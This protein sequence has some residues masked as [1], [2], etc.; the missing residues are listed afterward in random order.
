MAKSKHLINKL[1]T[2]AAQLNLDSSR[3][4]NVVQEVGSDDNGNTEL[5]N[6]LTHPVD[7]VEIRQVTKEVLAKT[8]ELRKAV[9]KC[10]GEEY[11]V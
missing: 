10:Q 7:C 1:K 2:V 8:P 5:I 4:G 6:T 9:V 11:Q 3:Y